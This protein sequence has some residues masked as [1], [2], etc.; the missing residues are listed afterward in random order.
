MTNMTTGGGIG[1]TGGYLRYLGVSGKQNNGVPISRNLTQINNAPETITLVE[2]Q[3]TSNLLGNGWQPTATAE[4]HYTRYKNGV[5]PHRQ[6]KSN[7]LM[8]DGHVEVF[9]FYK[10]LTTTSGTSVLATITSDVSDS[11]WDSSR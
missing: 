4:S 9:T 3:S 8:A 6:Q 11:Y 1:E 7:Y 2:N 5:L 10:T